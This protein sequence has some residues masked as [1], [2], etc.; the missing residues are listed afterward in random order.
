MTQ[1]Q[2]LTQDRKPTDGISKVHHSELIRIVAYDAG[3]SEDSTKKCIEALLANITKI[4]AYSKSITLQ[5]FGTF[6]GE[7]QP[8]RIGRN[9]ATGESILTP[10][11]T[12][13]KF[14]SSK[15]IKDLI[16]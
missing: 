11:K 2:K 9:P 5:K 8:E 7:H 10:A 15:F 4:M 14:R 6:S 3:I 1:E 13:P 16:A 12:V